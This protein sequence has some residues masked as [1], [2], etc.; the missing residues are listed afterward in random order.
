MQSGDYVQVVGHLDEGHFVIQVDS[1]DGALE[2]FR[3][4]FSGETPPRTGLFEHFSFGVRAYSNQPTHYEPFLMSMI[5]D[6]LNNLVLHVFL[7]S[8]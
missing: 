5:I 8:R 3:W 2:R 6:P 4:K 1:Q 7:A